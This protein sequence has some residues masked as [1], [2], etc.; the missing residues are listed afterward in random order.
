MGGKCREVAW[1]WR[2]SLGGGKKAGWG[3]TGRC[4]D[5]AVPLVG[6]EGNVVC[7]CVFEGNSSEPFHC[8]GFCGRWSCT[9]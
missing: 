3:E 7:T 2:R 8:R 5:L 9:A 6:V 4:L 1:G